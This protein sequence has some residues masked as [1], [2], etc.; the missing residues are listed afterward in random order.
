[1]VIATGYELSLVYRQGWNAAK[2]YSTGGTARLVVGDTLRLN[3]YSAGQESQRWNEGFRAAIRS[4]AAP[5]NTPG[6]SG[7]RPTKKKFSVHEE[8]D[9]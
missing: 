1:M 5:F 3:P 9:E 4:Q 7:W 6:G 2:N 8:F